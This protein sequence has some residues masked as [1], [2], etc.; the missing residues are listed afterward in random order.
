MGANIYKN[1]KK[2]V[3]LFLI[4]GFLFMAAFLYYPFFMNILNSFQQI[5]G[6]AGESRGFLDPWY[7]NYLEMLKDPNMLIALRNTLIL[8]VCTLVFQV[9][10]FQT[11]FVVALLVA[12][13]MLRKTGKPLQE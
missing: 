6:L 11:H 9:V 1:N 10:H 2:Y 13:L 4:P 7:S 8:M 3:A 12:L 5:K